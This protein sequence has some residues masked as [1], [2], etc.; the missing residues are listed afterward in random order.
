[1]YGDVGALAELVG[2][3]AALAGAAVLVGWLVARWRRAPALLL[4]APALLALL[5]VT[6]EAA[7]RLLPN[8]W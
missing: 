8:L 2:W 7:A 6:T 4:A 5:W 3:L 1:M